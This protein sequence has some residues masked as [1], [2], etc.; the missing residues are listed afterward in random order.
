MGSLDVISGPWSPRQ[1]EAHLT[2][3]RIPV[4]LASNGESFPLVQSLWFAYEDAALLCC[5][6]EDSVVARRLRRDPRCAFEV[7]A[8]QPPYRG[9][10]GRGI[11][12]VASAGAADLLPRLIE[13]YLGTEATP[14]S[15]RLLSKVDSEV[16]IRIDDLSVTSWDYSGRMASAVAAGGTPVRLP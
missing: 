4:R 11:A 16:V 5:T 6:Q 12:T 3:A 2:E 8:D 15:D 7:S 9:V 10:R 1:I 13:R 14:I